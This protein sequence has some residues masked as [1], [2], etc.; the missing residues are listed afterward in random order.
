MLRLVDATTE[1]HCRW[2]QGK[3]G[4][5]YLTRWPKQQRPFPKCRQKPRW[6]TDQERVGG[7]RPRGVVTGTEERAGR[8]AVSLPV[9]RR[10]GEKRRGAERS[11]ERRRSTRRRIRCRGR[12]T[13]CL[14][15]LPREGGSRGQKEECFLVRETGLGASLVNKHCCICG[16]LYPLINLFS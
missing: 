3:I 5:L 9:R 8:C 10:R 15:W 4:L 12:S 7:E 1:L 2:A 11:R 6:V 16:I 14:S 13:V